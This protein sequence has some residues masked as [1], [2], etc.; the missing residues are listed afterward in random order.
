[1]GLLA[2]G[3]DWL[4]ETLAACEGVA[5]TYAP[6]GGAAADLVAVPADVPVGVLVE[7]VRAARAVYRERFY[8]VAAADWAAAFGASA[9]TKAGDRVTETIAGTARTFEVT[10]RDGEPCWR[11]LDP[12]RTALQ[13]HC[14]GA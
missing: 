7:Q 3:M 4:S 2:E 8:Q 5:V 11:W 12:E 14:K 9:Q 10:D 13:V 6:L 1:M